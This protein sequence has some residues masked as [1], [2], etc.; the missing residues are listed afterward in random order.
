MVR[1]SGRV[2]ESTT[3]VQASNAIRVVSKV[4]AI[5]NIDN[6]I[7]GGI[8]LSGTLKNPNYH[9]GGP[10]LHAF[11]LVRNQRPG[12]LAAGA[13]PNGL[14]VES[15][16]IAVFPWSQI[17]RHV[18]TNRQLLSPGP[19]RHDLMLTTLRWNVFAMPEGPLIWPS[20]TLT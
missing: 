2:E 12:P 5:D 6:N 17:S 15:A 7:I 8:T 16:V 10:N 4:G 18:S 13:M 9:L 3:F 1:Q 11:S 19:D 14:I 20:S